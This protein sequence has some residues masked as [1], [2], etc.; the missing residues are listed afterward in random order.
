MSIRL[1]F[2]NLSHNVEGAT[3]FFFISPISYINVDG[4]IGIFLAF[5]IHKIQKQLYFEDINE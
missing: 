2:Q 4:A 3:C 1:F 5:Y